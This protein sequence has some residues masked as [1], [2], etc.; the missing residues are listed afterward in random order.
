MPDFTRRS[1]L[2]T[3]LAAR[4]I[5]FVP[6]WIQRASDA[7]TAI[8]DTPKSPK[9][10]LYAHREA[11]GLFTLCLDG[12]RYAQPPPLTIREFIAKW[13]QIP[14]SRVERLGAGHLEFEYRVARQDLDKDASNA[15]GY[16]NYLEWWSANASPE[17]NGYKYVRR[18]LDR[19]SN[20]QDSSESLGGIRLY[21]PETPLCNFWAAEGENVFSL[22]CLQRAL[23]RL[24]E[25]SAVVL[26]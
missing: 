7:G 10:I 8:L 1:F 9:H 21:S 11:S 19:V 12:P 14:I 17:A 15:E 18:L 25:N 23:N 26:S 4:T 13:E 22:Q 5:L 20:L 16:S 6:E 2:K 24:G 3:S